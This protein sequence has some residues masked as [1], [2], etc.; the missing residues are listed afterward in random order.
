MALCSDEKVQK[1]KGVLQTD[2]TLSS[3]LRGF[4]P[5]LIKYINT[6]ILPICIV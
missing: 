6:Y 5:G 3:W 2:A 4:K 1:L